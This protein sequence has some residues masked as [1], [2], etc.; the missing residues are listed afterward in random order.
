[1]ELDQHNTDRLLLF[2]KQSHNGNVAYT[3]NQNEKPNKHDFA[4]LLDYQD[5]CEVF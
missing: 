3:L 5:C 1:M 4:S 2:A